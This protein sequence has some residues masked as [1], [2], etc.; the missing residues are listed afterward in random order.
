M[1]PAPKTPPGG[2]GKRGGS[3]PGRTREAAALVVAA[4]TANAPP[5]GPEVHEAE[6]TEAPARPAEAPSS[7]DRAREILAKVRARGGRPPELTRE[8]IERVVA[9]ILDGSPPMLALKGQGFAESTYGEW[10]RRAAADL[11]KDPPEVTLHVEFSAAVDLAS[12]VF[13]EEAAAWMSRARD[14]RAGTNQPNVV[15]FLLKS[16]HREIFADQVR[17]V[18]LTG[19]EGGPV[20]T[21]ALPPREAL[22]AEIAAKLGP[23]ATAFFMTMRRWPTSLEEVET[24]RAERAK[25]T[26]GAGASGA[27]EGIG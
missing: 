5:P 12:G 13:G 22:F 3:R 1:P 16:H 20:Q 2:K 18:E 25:A 19:A 23:D 17:K 15:Q 9:S 4:R 21:E 14:T 11:A 27:G 26:P 24:W 7:A 10:R 6:F 8:L